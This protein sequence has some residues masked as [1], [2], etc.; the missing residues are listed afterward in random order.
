MGVGAWLWSAA[1]DEQLAQSAVLATAV[2]VV[3][4]AAALV[5]R[6][7]AAIPFAIALLASPYVAILALE[8]DGLDTAAPALAGALYLVAELAYWSLELRGHIADEAGTYLRRAAV[9]LGLVLT[10]VA[11]GTGLLVVVEVVAARGAAVDVLGT[12]AA[13]GAIALLALAAAAR[14]TS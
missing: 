10:T 5:L 8:T 12:V 6:R 13:V 1:D 2:T 4:L 14:R 9:L 3:G 11:L 7:P